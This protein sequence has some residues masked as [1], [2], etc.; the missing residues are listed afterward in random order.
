MYALWHPNSPVCSW[1]SVYCMHDTANVVNRSRNQ[2]DTLQAILYPYSLSSFDSQSRMVRWSVSDGQ[3]VILS[4]PFFT[5]AAKSSDRQMASF[6]L[7]GLAH[8]CPAVGSVY[9][10]AGGR[11]ESV[12]RPGWSVRLTYLSASKVRWGPPSA[13]SCQSLKYVRIGSRSC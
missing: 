7:R 6:T 5:P 8:R 4:R 2:N 12:W 1:P 3:S 13:S 9:S 11:K 10:S